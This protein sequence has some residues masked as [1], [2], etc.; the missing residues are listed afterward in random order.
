MRPFRQKA[1]LAIRRL[2]QIL[3]LPGPSRLAR[4]MTSALEEAYRYAAGLTRPL[5]LEGGGAPQQLVDVLACPTT[6]AGDYPL[7]LDLCLP[8]KNLRSASFVREQVHPAVLKKL[9]SEKQII[10]LRTL[11]RFCSIVIDHPLHEVAERD[12]IIAACSELICSVIERNVA[13]AVASSAAAGRGGVEGVE[14]DIQ[15]PLAAIRACSQEL[16]R[17]AFA[18]SKICSEW[19][20]PGRNKDKRFIDALIRDMLVLQGEVFTAVDTG[21]C[22]VF[23][24]V[25]TSGS[26]LPDPSL[27]SKESL[28]YGVLPVI[29][30]LSKTHVEANMRCPALFAAL[31]GHLLAII[32]TAYSPV[33][34]SSIPTH[35]SSRAVLSETLLSLAKQAALDRDVLLAATKKTVAAMKGALRTMSMPTIPARR[36]GTTNTSAYANARLAITEAT[37]LIEALGLMGGGCGDNGNN[38]NEDDAV[39]LPRER[40]IE[41]QSLLLSLFQ[42]V[43]S[44]S[45]SPSPSVVATEAWVI[46]DVISKAGYAPDDELLRLMRPLV[47]SASRGATFNHPPSAFL[48]Y[49]VANRV[50]APPLYPEVSMFSP[51][52][53]YKRFA[54]PYGLLLAPFASS[55]SDAQKPKGPKLPLLSQI[56]KHYS[57]GDAASRSIPR[58]LL[59][60]SEGTDGAPSSCSSSPLFSLTDLVERLC[61]DRGIEVKLHRYLRDE[62][63]EQVGSDSFDADG[64]K[65]L[66]HRLIDHMLRKSCGYYEDHGINPAWIK[67]RNLLIKVAISPVP[68][69]RFVPQ[70][71]EGQAVSAAKILANADWSLSSPHESYY[72][73]LFAYSFEKAP[74]GKIQCGDKLAL[75]PA[76]AAREKALENVLCQQAEVKSPLRY[77]RLNHS[78]IWRKVKVEKDHYKEGID[79]GLVEAALEDAG[80]WKFLKRTPPKPRGV[81]LTS[82]KQL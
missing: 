1:A 14:M 26:K 5:N 48:N 19:R 3:Q 74:A 45:S 42:K 72:N 58:P 35:A 64:G 78:L 67:D 70:S 49:L 4:R 73:H 24:D 12:D 25:N 23:T 36:G 46:L 75:L 61:Y 69:S 27:L 32:D 13:I 28:L 71:L 53:P 21:I 76:Y 68:P 9:E 16:Q 11:T 65:L 54:E 59:F 51:H 62:E 50:V 31:K 20:L 44:G 41:L 6:L 18:C 77:V 15:Q 40:A 34:S 57:D 43:Y 17:F 39:L 38:N 55:S 22:K 29:Y 47:A 8:L 60:Q 52:S 80:L 56:L 63:E 2:H 79:E 30:H 37:T 7:L 10:P 66:T 82:T 33:S 81:L